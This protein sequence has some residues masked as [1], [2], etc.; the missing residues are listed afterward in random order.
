MADYLIDQLPAAT[1][2]TNESL[3]VVSQETYAKKLSGQVFVNWL[4]NYADGHGGIQSITKVS[5]TGTDPVVDTYRITYAD[6]GYS[7]FTVTNG[8]KGEEGP[9]G[10]PISI[11]S[12]TVEYAASASGTTIPSTGWQS[13]VPT[14]Q[15]GNFLW[16][17]TTVVYGDADE[18]NVV[19]YTVSRYGVDGAGSVSSV[20]SVGPDGSGNVVLTPSDIGAASLVNGK[21]DPEEASSDMVSYT[22]S[23]TLSLSDA[24]KFINSVNNTTSP[25]TITVPTKASVAFP[26]GTEI[27]ILQRGSYDVSIVGA[28]GV[29]IW[30]LGGMTTMAG[31][32]AVVCLKKIADNVWL[33]AGALK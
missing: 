21:V 23:F 33:L 31:E 29:S 4:T 12:Y 26:I 1:Q 2:V 15:G 32:F 3:F 8:L 30:S 6:E 19:S 25:I 14:V 10:P 22:S 24:G 20:N 13:T 17:R 28:A 7:E 18:T 16:T 11:D 5:S 9:E 27:E